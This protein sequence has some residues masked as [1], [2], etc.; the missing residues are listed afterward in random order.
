MLKPGGVYVFTVPHSTDVH[1][2][3]VRVR[4]HDPD[5]PSKDEHLMEPE[6]HGDLNTEDGTGALAYR[7]Y[8]NVLLDELLARSGSTF[9]TAARTTTCTASAGPSCSTA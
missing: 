5:D 4:V 2:T 6:Y 8:G 1:E 7:F 3:L 9:V